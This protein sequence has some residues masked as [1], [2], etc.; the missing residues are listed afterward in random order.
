M[1]LDVDWQSLSAMQLGRYAEYYARMAF[2]A[3][4]FEVFSSEVD[5]RGVDFVVRC[6]KGPFFEVQV[7]SL[8]GKG[9]VFMR[10]DNMSLTPE[11][12]IALLVLTGT[13]S[14]ELYLIPALAWRTPDALLASMDY[15]EGKKSAP[16]WGIRVSKKNAALL[17]RYRFR[18]VCDRVTSGSMAWALEP[19]VGA[20]TLSALTE[21]FHRLI[22]QRSL[23]EMGRAEVPLPSLQYCPLSDTMAAWHPVP[24]LYGG[25]RYWL[26]L[27][28]E[29]PTLR[30]ASWSRVV[31]GS[32]QRHVITSTTVQL[33]EE[34]FV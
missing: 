1:T 21:Q 34:G 33:V 20:E 3:H 15:G 2:A 25:F 29:E 32:G 22:R 23:E 8:R 27:T 31:Q 24:G 28:A 19:I 4:G 5:D 10:K 14:S 17:N 12:L 13:R 6:K 26:D 7:K 11:R 30:V 9:Y 18:D 16:E